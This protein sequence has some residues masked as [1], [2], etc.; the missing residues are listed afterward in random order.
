MTSILQWC[1]VAFAAFYMHSMA[2]TEIVD[3]S[4]LT[5]DRNETL[6]SETSLFSQGDPCDPDTLPPY[7][8]ID[9][10]NPIFTGTCGIDTWESKWNQNFVDAE[11]SCCLQPTYLRLD[12]IIEFLCDQKIKESWTVFIVVWDGSEIGDPCSST[13]SPEGYF[14]DT[15]LFRVD[16][17]DSIAPVIRN[18]PADVTVA[19]SA[20]LPSPPM[21]TASDTCDG[22][23]SQAISIDSTILVVGCGFGEEV[24]VR[25]YKATVTD[26]CGNVGTAEWKVFVVSDLVVDLG[27]DIQLCANEQYTIDAGVD[28]ATYLWSTE[29]EDTTQTI[30]VT[31]DGTYTVMV[32]DG[33]G[34]CSID[35]IKVT[36]SSPVAT[37]TTLPATNG[38]DGIA[39]VEVEQGL[40]PYTYAWSNGE[41]TDTIRNLEV[42]DYEVT[43]TDANLCTDK[44]SFFIEA[45][46]TVCDLAFTSISTNTTV[47]D[48]LTN[49]RI[50]TSSLLKVDCL[51]EAFG[52]PVPEPLM[53]RTF[54]YQHKSDIMSTTLE[55]SSSEN[56]K[57]FI[58]T[59]ESFEKHTVQTC[60]GMSDDQSNFEFN[61]AKGLYYIVIAG[62]NA[63]EYSF[64]IDANLPPTPC[65]AVSGEISCG[66]TRMESV[67]G[68]NTFSTITG[69]YNVCYGRDEDKFL[70]PE[71]VY[72]YEVARSVVA[73]IKLTPQSEMGIFLFN[74]ECASQC[75]STFEASP[76]TL[77][78]DEI[79]LNP[80]L[81]FI[82]I[83][84]TNADN[85]GNDFVL[86]IDCREIDDQRWPPRRTSP[87]DCPFGDSVH[88]IEFPR[89]SISLDPSLAGNSDSVRVYFMEPNLEEQIGSFKTVNIA[90]GAT[91]MAY[92]DM[93]GDDPTCG[94]L[95]N[96]TITYALQTD[97]NQIL[98]GQPAYANGP[99][100][101][102]P[103]GVSKISEIVQ[104]E[105]KPAVLVNL[106]PLQKKDARSDPT[107]TEFTVET[108]DNQAWELLEPTASWVD[109]VYLQSDS[110][111]RRGVGVKTVIVRHT[112]NNSPDERTMAIVVDFEEVG[113][114]NTRIEITQKGRTSTS[115][116]SVSDLPGLQVFPNPSSG[117]VYVEFDKD[118]AVEADIRVFDISGKLVHNVKKFIGTQSPVEIDLSG[119]LPG[120]YLIEV[121]IGHK[122]AVSKVI[123]GNAD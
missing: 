43:V 60:I 62:P 39:W 106:K 2:T 122:A 107:I 97:G 1:S 42:S 6:I 26:E 61:G 4:D 72:K 49:H 48:S 114:P 102:V 24:E 8:L 51:Q 113:I 45:Q 109:D 70:G 85:D 30:T 23:L 5:N 64:S 31:Q 112:V 111:S 81:Y 94:Y 123:L 76:N 119:N 83:D 77:T 50:A 98:F 78:E 75:I 15:L 9:S 27:S 3:N 10:L 29:D 7:W 108:N 55:L 25:T 91:L 14:S 105:G 38:V 47:S 59:C 71:K 46:I 22:D 32:V 54:L 37:V 88:L 87:E 79:M 74:Y 17:Y 95:N 11:D 90:A 19:C 89:F 35:S 68:V 80:G 104:I 69:T 44:V 92:G 65:D 86:E 99:A 36:F 118:D 66:E 34:C 93:P 58:F 117:L 110:S 20:A 41:T 84:K 82:V 63:G 101:F 52:S 33:D 40:P 21:L 120:V 12:T 67:S 121:K 13:G 100:T 16:L 115:T 57:A 56:I 73:T 53:A 28:N 96:E 18:V 103:G 116:R